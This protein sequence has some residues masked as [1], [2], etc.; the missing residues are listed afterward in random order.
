MKNNFSYALAIFLFAFAIIIFTAIAFKNPH[1]N[2]EINSYL[3]AQKKIVTEKIGIENWD[4][5]CAISNNISLIRTNKIIL[6]TKIFFV[7]SAATLL[8]LIIF[9]GTLIK[10]HNNRSNR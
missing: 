4:M 10:R 9:I 5:F 3:E 7:L 6:A 8:S 2:T 1:V